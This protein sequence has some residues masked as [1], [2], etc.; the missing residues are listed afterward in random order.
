MIKTKTSIFVS[1]FQLAMIVAS[2]N[3]SLMFGVFMLVLSLCIRHEIGGLEAT[4]KLYRDMANTQP[5]EDLEEKNISISS[6]IKEFFVYEDC[7]IENFDDKLFRVTLPDGQ[8]LEKL[9]TSADNAKKEIDTLNIRSV[10]YNKRNRGS[11]R[12]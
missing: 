5:E 2:F 11:F 6:N 7:V 3:H 1:I 8:V 4:I 12:F 10:D 9:Y